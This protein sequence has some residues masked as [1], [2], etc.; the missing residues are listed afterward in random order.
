MP[1]PWRLPFDLLG[2]PPGA[3]EPAH[4]AIQIA[5]PHIVPSMCGGLVYSSATFEIDEVEP[6]PGGLYAEDTFGPLP[7]DAD[8]DVDLAAYAAERFTQRPQIRRAGEILLGTAILHPW[9][10]RFA[11]PRVIAAAGVAS[12]VADGLLYGCRAVDNEGRVVLVADHADARASDFHVGANALGELA[13]RAG[14]AFEGRLRRIPVLAAGL[15]SASWRE[16]RI[17]YRDATLLYARV[18]DAVRALSDN[19]EDDAA[20]L[21]ERASLTAEIQREIEILFLDGL[22]AA[23][24]RAAPGEARLVPLAHL[25]TGDLGRACLQH[26][27]AVD[28]AEALVLALRGTLFIWRAH[29]EASCLEIVPLAEDGSVDEDARDQSFIDRAAGTF[30][31]VYTEQLGRCWQGAVL[32]GPDTPPH[33]DVYSFDPKAP[34]QP[35][36]IIT[37]GA[38]TAALVAAPPD[39]DPF[40]ELVTLVPRDLDAERREGMMQALLALARYPFLKDTFFAKGH[41]VSIG[42][43][44]VPGSGLSAWVIYE[45]DEDWTERLSDALPRHPRFLHAVAVTAEE[46]AFKIEHGSAALYERL[47]AAGTHVSDPRRG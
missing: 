26:L 13:R 19:A 47:R 8:G 46:Q 24:R 30:N 16:G 14:S 39:A 12:D 34:G 43:P 10:R 15:R 23:G 9:L 27:A 17:V 32:H 35:A 45:L 29:V 44:I 21:A 25:L 28:S 6:V 1:T 36:V 31:D 18:I 38:S 22:D 11:L 20:T 33:V 7:R 5:P 41:D 2:L 3:P 42:R 4:A 37:A 40:I